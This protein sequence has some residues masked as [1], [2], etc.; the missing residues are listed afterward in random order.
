MA[1]KQDRARVIAITVRLRAPDGR[2]VVVEIDPRAHDAVLFTAAAVEK[3]LGPF[4]R[5]HR[6]PG[7]ASR[8]LAR[9]ASQLEVI[10]GTGV[11]AHRMGTALRVAPVDWR[12]PSVRV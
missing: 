2:A 8:I 1:G 9:V 10:G 7:S 3:L 11:V 4:Y 12:R 5:A 6:G